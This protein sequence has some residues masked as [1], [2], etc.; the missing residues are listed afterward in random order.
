[1]SV[2]ITEQEYKEFIKAMKEWENKQN[3]K[4]EKFKNS[5]LYRI[6]SFVI[7]NNTKKA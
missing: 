6:Y 2:Q 5:L 4:K 3:I 7:N 1:M